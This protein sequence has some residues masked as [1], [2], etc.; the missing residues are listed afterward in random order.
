MSSRSRK[1]LASVDDGLLHATT[2]AQVES[3]TWSGTWKIK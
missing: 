3:A 2:K 1:S